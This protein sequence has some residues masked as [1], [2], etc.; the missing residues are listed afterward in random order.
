MKINYYLILIFVWLLCSATTCKKVR[1]HDT[2]HF[3]NNSS[4][5]VYV[6]G[7]F[8][9]DTLK[10]ISWLPYPYKSS[11]PDAYKVKSGEKNSYALSSRGCHEAEVKSGRIVVFVFDA[12]VLANYSWGL[13]GKDYMVLKTYHPTIE[14]MTSSNWTITYTVE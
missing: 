11:P 5:D 6:V 1:C 3:V 12:E 14:E 8:C 4:K 10:F 2:I 13:I 7:G 9:P